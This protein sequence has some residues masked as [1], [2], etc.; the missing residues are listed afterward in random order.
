MEI[1]KR[2]PVYVTIFAIAIALLAMFSLATVMLTP[3][4]RTEAAPAA[5]LPQPVPAPV[6]TSGTVAAVTGGC[7]AHLVIEREGPVRPALGSTTINEAEIVK[8]ITACVGAG[9]IKETNVQV[10][11]AQCTKQETLAAAPVCNAS[12]QVS[13]QDKP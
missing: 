3:A 13:L 9:E 5:Q 2:Y 4:N 8:V 10:F 12:V 1:E 11:T 6:T 7:S